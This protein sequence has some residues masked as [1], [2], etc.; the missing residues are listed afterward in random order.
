M[1]NSNQKENSLKRGDRIAYSLIL[2]WAVY[3]TIRDVLQI[4]GVGNF[5]TTAW[6][7]DHVW[8]RAYCDYITIPV[9]LFVIIA[10]IIILR[11]GRAGKLGGIVVLCLF[12]FIIM[13]FWK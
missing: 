13:W 10:S 9:E 11:R 2:F 3:H 7:R 6:S 8:C 1:S 5:L 12:L 4:L